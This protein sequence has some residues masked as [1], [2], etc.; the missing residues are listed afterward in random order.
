MTIYSPTPPSCWKLRFDAVITAEQVKSYKPER[1]HWLEMLHRCKT[2][3]GAR[4]ARGAEHLSR[5]GSGESHGVQN[6]LGASRTRVMARQ[7]LPKSSLIW[8]FR[9]WKS[10]AGLAERS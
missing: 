9:I 5:R 7:R 3:S 8:K 4:A 6:G 10:L 2:T 1:A